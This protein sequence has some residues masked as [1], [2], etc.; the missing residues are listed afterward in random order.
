MNASPLPPQRDL[1]SAEEQV[2]ADAVARG[3]I[4]SDALIAARDKLF[5]PYRKILAI[6][7]ANGLLA[8]VLGVHLAVVQEAKRGER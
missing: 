4:V 6:A 7:G 2:L 1:M 3:T 8:C 5:D